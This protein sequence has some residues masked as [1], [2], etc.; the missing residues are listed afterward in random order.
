MLHFDSLN[1]KYCVY[2]LA[3]GDFK[4]NVSA[5]TLGVRKLL[6]APIIDAKFII[7]AKPVAL[8]PE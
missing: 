7:S 3:T 5:L 8:H 2:E 4:G 6:L 1:V